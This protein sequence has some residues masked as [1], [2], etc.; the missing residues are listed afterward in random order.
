MVKDDRDHYGY[1]CHVCVV[2]EHE[3]TVLMA[4]EP[5]HPDVEW[6][7]GVPVIVGKA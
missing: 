4:S 6:L 7:D 2:R 1:A 3:L 5:D